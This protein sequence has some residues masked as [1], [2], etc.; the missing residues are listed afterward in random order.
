M[1]SRRRGV[2]RR[3]GLEDAQTRSVCC[4]WTMGQFPP[5]AAGAGSR[6]DAAAPFLT[7]GLWEHHGERRQEPRRKRG[8]HNRRRVGHCACRY[9]P[10][11][12]NGMRISRDERRMKQR[13]AIQFER[14]LFL[15]HMPQSAPPAWHL[16]CLLSAAGA[17]HRRRTGLRDAIRSP[18]QVT[19]DISGRCRRG[20][21]RR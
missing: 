13:N 16:R 4:R 10:E 15:R 19:I 1:K 2:R 20:S 18:N 14:L 7:R 6:L 21:K 9:T 8:R 12:T 3:I 17:A 5:A 11:L